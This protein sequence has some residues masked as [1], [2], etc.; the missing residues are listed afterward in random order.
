MPVSDNPLETTTEEATKVTG[1]PESSDQVRPQEAEATQALADSTN[2][3]LAE[4][5]QMIQ[6]SN[7]PLIEKINTLTTNQQELNQTMTTSNQQMAAATPAPEETD[8]LTELTSGNAESAIAKVVQKELQGILPVISG[9]L[10]N[11]SSTFVD[12]EAVG[13][14]ERFGS[15]AWAKFFQT[16]INQIMANYAKSDPKSMM[17]R[18]VIGHEVNGLVGQQFE[19]L[20]T[21]RNADQKTKTESETDQTSTLVDTVVSEVV[22]R[23]NGIG[24]IRQI[25]ASGNISITPEV[26]GYLAERSRA[27]GKPIDAKEWVK[28]TDFGHDID[29]YRE[30][31][32][33]SIEGAA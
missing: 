3:T 4:A 19:E 28:E 7:A 21:Y 22:N 6:E 25:E 1:T 13:I 9:M 8:F 11:G 31:L 14:D 23:T 26:E 24:G 18:S 20:L 5:V 10:Q 30:S 27:I 16:P 32:Q 15:G 17:D 29:S 12:L 2:I 33:T